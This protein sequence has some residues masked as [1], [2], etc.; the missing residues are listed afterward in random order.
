MLFLYLL[1]QPFHNG[2]RSIDTNIS[3]NQDFFQ[4]L[5]E[6]I[7]YLRKTVEYRIQALDDIVPGLGQTF[8][9]PGK[10]AFLF[11]A[12]R[13][14]SS[15]SCIFLS[16]SNCT[17]HPYSFPFKKLFQWILRQI[18]VYQIY[19]YQSGHALFLHGDT[20]QSVHFF[21]SASSMSDHDKLC[22]LRQLVQIF[23][24]SAHV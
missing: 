13:F 24:K 16:K 6:I 7:I 1:F 9:Q 23:C 3:H 5:V 17:N 20:I 21:H 12:H 4:L 14:R 2:V 18:L 19:A 10:K 8:F 15:L 22:I 11:L